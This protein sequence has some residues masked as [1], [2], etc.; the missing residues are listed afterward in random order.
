MITN[1]DDINLNG[2]K[3]MTDIRPGDK[4]IDILVILIQLA[5]KNK[6]KN[7]KQITQFIVADET[8]SILCNFY[9]SIGDIIKEG[10]IILLTGAYASVFKGHLILYSG[11]TGFGQIIKIDEY[12]MTYSDTPNLSEPL[13]EEKEESERNQKYQNNS[14]K[15]YERTNNNK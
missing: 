1:I 11:K 6:L 9:D 7:D 14:N 4:N 3:K 13:Y 10:D 12:F 5:N 2:N 8:G 15:H